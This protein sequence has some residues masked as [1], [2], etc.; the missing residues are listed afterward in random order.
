MDNSVTVA[1]G[2]PDDLRSWIW[3]L[4]VQG[5]EVYFGATPLLRSIKVSLH[6]TGKWHIAWNKG[7][8]P[9]KEK[10]RIICRWVRPP[11]L[12]SGFVECIAVFVDPY[13]AKEPFKNKAILNSDIKWLPLAPYGKYLIIKV[14]IA[15][16]K[17]DMDSHRIPTNERILARLRKSNGEQA[18]LM[19]GEHPITLELG[20]RF[21]KNR[22][23]P[24]IHFR[25]E[26][27]D[28]AELF[29]MTRAVS[30]G[31]PRFPHEIP[32][33]YDLSLGWENVS[34]EPASLKR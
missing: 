32:V 4:W 22:S 26:D 14:L 8:N 25:P 1:V 13:P 7:A 19:A 33:I 28:R 24:K 21:L 11:P 16:A 2:S 12:K 30:F 3:R 34:P 15:T 27:I 20:Q 5:D 29:D 10:T 6:K 17:A 9:N 23:D 31:F 18:V